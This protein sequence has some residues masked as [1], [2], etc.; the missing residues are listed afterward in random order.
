MKRLIKIT[1]C[2]IVFLFL[3]SPSALCVDSNIDQYSEEYDFQSM[4][5]TLDDNTLEILEEIGITE[6][7]YDTVFSIEP[8]KIF[9]ALFNII[10]DAVKSPFKFTI[11]ALGILIL[12]SVF[13]AVVQ[14]SDSVGMIGGGVL[15][16]TVAVPVA[17]VVTTAF[18]VI[19]ALLVFTTAFAGVF[20]AIVSS[21]GN[22]TMGISYASFT[23]FSNTVFSSAI[24]NFSQPVIKAMCSVGFLSCFDI[25]KLTERFTSIIKKVYVVL[26][27]FV[28]TV[29]SG[30]VT[31]KGVLSEGADSLSARSIRFVIGQ[32]LP[33]V[34]GA[35]SETY[36]TLISSLSLI[37]NTVGAFGIITVIVFVLPTLIQL[38]MWMLSMEIISTAAQS[39]GAESATSVITV[40]KDALVLLLATVVILT[41]IFIVSVGVCIHTKGGAV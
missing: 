7:S 29:F 10:A 19:E 12:V 34:G 15:A 31:L 3:V 13:S 9:N 17:Q 14:K 4:F 40:L 22:L 5:D 6:I 39:F 16:L 21:S 27:S 35:V 37:K 11:V 32:S 28:G 38:I 33:V 25:Y 41:T 1:I 8:E 26:L 30:L 18:S 2:S 23:V 24:T 36:S 20:C